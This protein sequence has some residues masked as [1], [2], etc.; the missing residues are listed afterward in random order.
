MSL[1][2]QI[3]AAVVSVS[4]VMAASAG[5]AGDKDAARTLLDTSVKASGGME[6]AGAWKT[7]TKTGELTANWPG[8]GELRA[9]CS[10]K[11]K[12]PDKL[13]L[14]QDFT[15]H[16]HPFFFTFFYNGGETWTVINLGVR[17]NPHYAEA[18][19]RAMKDTGGMHYYL[20][21]CDTFFVVAAV[22]DDSLVVASSIDRVGIV[23]NGDTVMV[24]LDR[25]THLPV[26]LI[27][28]AGAEQ[29]L[30]SDYRTVGPLTVPFKMTVYENG[31]AGA[32]YVWESILFDEPIDEAVFEEHRPTKAEPS[33]G[34]TG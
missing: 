2:K 8:W 29:T 3:A 25:Q 30:F 9:E 32:E 6:A 11:V 31:A 13:V 15:V 21:E 27:R 22:P 14:D 1:Q 24:D 23:D 20:T 7:M 17:Q 5:I 18:T 12:R 10:L 28:D 4:L 19:T 16:D 26:R 34:S 33:S